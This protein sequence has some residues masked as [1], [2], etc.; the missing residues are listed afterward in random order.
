MTSSVAIVAIVAML[1]AVLFFHARSVAPAGA[2]P[3]EVILEIR[4]PQIV[5]LT[6]PPIPDR[7]PRR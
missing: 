3:G 7:N 4:P 1:F 6:T 5:Y 2:G